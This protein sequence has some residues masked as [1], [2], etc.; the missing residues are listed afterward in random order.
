MSHTY[1]VIA[2]DTSG[3]FSIGDILTPWI[4]QGWE[5][6]YWVTNHHLKNRKH[7]IIRNPEKFPH[8]FEKATE[9]KKPDFDE[10]NYGGHKH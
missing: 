1:K 7:N 9:N 8:L 6:G 5:D 3:N 4:M 10:I 2:E